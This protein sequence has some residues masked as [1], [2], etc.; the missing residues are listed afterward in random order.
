[1]KFHI[2]L[3]GCLRYREKH[4]KDACCCLQTCNSVVYVVVMGLVLGQRLMVISTM[5]ILLYAKVS[6]LYNALWECIVVVYT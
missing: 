4:V 2:H 3:L 5:G 1:M 6:P